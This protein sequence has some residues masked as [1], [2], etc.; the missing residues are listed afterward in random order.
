MPVFRFIYTFKWNEI[1]QSFRVGFERG[2]NKWKFKY[3]ENQ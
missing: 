2:E 1:P 3:T